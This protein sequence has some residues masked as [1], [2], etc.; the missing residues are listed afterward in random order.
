M[1]IYELI[2]PILNNIDTKVKASKSKEAANNIWM[3]LTDGKKLFAN[4]VHNFIFT[5]KGGKKNDLYHFSVRENE[6]TETGKIKFDIKNITKKVAGT[7]EKVMNAFLQEVDKVKSQLNGETTY[8]GGKRRRDK[9]LKKSTT[10]DSSDSS[11]DSDSD[12]DSDTDQDNF[13]NKLRL[14]NNRHKLSYWW[15]S[16]T[17]YR[18]RRIFTPTFAPQH[19]PYVQLWIPQ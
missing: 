14:R 13:F 12:T 16:P 18:V 8:K 7:D 19:A 5:L 2:N 3:M 6:D 15:Y 17:I 10:S 11:T 4:D 9:D 1:P